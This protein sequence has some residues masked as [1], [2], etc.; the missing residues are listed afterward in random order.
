MQPAYGLLDV[1]GGAT[2]N[3]MTAQLI[4]TNVTNRLA[5]LSRFAQTVPSSEN[6]PY[7]VPTQPRT[8]AIQ[9]GQ[10]F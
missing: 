8:F 1:F 4:V 9:F 5:E 6:Q 3:N 2:Y 10:K 7:V